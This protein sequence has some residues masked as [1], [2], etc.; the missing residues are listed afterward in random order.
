M[1]KC[2]YELPN[3]RIVAI[4]VHKSLL[5]RRVLN[6]LVSFFFSPSDYVPD[7][8]SDF[9]NALANPIKYQSEL[10]KRSKQLSI[11]TGEIEDPNDVTFRSLTQCSHEMNAREM[12][13]MKIARNCQVKSWYPF[14]DPADSKPSEKEEKERNEKEPKIRDNV[15][16]SLDKEPSSVF[17]VPE[18]TP[19]MEIDNRY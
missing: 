7:G 18:P 1:L 6:W 15:P 9:A 16:T 19:S 11:L 8:L 3:K 17:Y 10:E 12:R 4:D 2:C 13:V 5:L 14:Q